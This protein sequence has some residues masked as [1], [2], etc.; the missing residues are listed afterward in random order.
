MSHDE[1]VARAARWLRNTQ[2]CGVV[3]TEFG[4]SS[5]EIPDAIGWATGGRFSTLV[6]CKT[7]R[8]DFYADKKKPGRVGITASHGIGRYRYYMTPPGV[9]SVDLVREHRP[10]WG[11]LEVKPRTIRTLLK[12][13]QFPLETAWRELPLLYSYARRIEQFGLPLDL[14]QLAVQREADSRARKAGVEVIEVK[15]CAR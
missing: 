6:E 11:L 12:A 1:L 4:S 15:P 3:L 9:L 13:E 2:G 14:A 7:S 10:K 8:S 5:I